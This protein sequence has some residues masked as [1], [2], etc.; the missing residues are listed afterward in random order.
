MAIIQPQ[1][2]KVQREMLQRGSKGM[3]YEGQGSISRAAPSV[4]YALRQQQSEEKKRAF[5]KTLC[6][7]AGSIVVAG[8]AI[9]VLSKTAEE[10]WD[11]VTSAGASEAG[12]S[13]PALMALEAAQAADPRRTDIEFADTAQEFLDRATV[14]GVRF[15]GKQTRAI[16][17]G[18]IYHVG[19][20]VAEDIG[21]VFVGHDPDGEY[22][23]FQDS[24]KQTVFL[25]VKN[26]EAG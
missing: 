10:S 20:T 5:L 9:Y 3:V 24:D 22:L 23:L 25:K 21:L 11:A 2:S 19:D 13:Q 1:S 17:N 18:S 6:I 12:S 7:I 4:Q 15:G 14:N 8:V 26:N 16:I